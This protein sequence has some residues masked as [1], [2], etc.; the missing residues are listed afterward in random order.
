MPN[1]IIYIYGKLFEEYCYDKINIFKQQILL[2][3]YGN[4]GYTILSIHICN[5]KIRIDNMSNGNWNIILI[6]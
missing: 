6:I 1:M 4:G 3:L 5:N 2:F